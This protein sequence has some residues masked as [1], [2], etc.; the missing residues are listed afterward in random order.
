[1]LKD[2][3]V[4]GLCDIER[5]DPRHS[6]LKE[7]DLALVAEKLKLYFLLSFQCLKPFEDGHYMKFDQLIDIG[8]LLTIVLGAIRIHCRI[9]V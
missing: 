2:R 1:M 6:S 8:W 5:N 4:W 7:G 9:D 3:F